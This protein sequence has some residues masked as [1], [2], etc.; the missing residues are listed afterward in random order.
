[1]D[2]S[3]V[4]KL[5]SQRSTVAGCRM[6]VLWMHSANTAVAVFRMLNSK[7]KVANL[8]GEDSSSA[9]TLRKRNGAVTLSELKVTA[10]RE[11]RLG[12]R[13]RLSERT[14]EPNESD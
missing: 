10:T 8:F 5:S 2:A 13:G 3:S 1:M 7:S 4:S 12:S 11:F 6:A 9:S 14:N